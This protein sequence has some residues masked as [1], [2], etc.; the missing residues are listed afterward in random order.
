[1]KKVAFIRSRHI[2]VRGQD[3][4]LSD[5]V[6][7]RLDDRHYPRTK[8]LLPGLEPRTPICGWFCRR[9]FRSPEG[10]CAHGKCRGTRDRHYL[11]PLK[12]EL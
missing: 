8:I 9:R 12:N 5:Q 10:G 6:L 1:M 11:Q 3:G 2:I 4:E 7:Y